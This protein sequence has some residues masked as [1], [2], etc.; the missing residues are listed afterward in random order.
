MPIRINEIIC[1]TEDEKK[2]LLANILG[3]M[4]KREL[5]AGAYSDDTNKLFHIA[6]SI[7]DNRNNNVIMRCIFTLHEREDANEILDIDFVLPNENLTKIKFIEKY[8][9]SSLANERWQ[10]E[11]NDHHTNI[12]T[13]NRHCYFENLQNKEV[14]VSLSLFPY[15]GIVFADSL[16]DINKEF[17]FKPT[18][19][20]WQEALNMGD[21][22]I[23]LGFG[24]D[25]V[26]MNMYVG[27]VADVKEY[28]FNICN[29][30]YKCI[31]AD[32]VTGLGKLPVIFSIDY[33]EQISKGKY[34]KFM[35]ETKADF[36]SNNRKFYL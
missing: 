21:E 6:F 32:I 7:K 1:K 34:V 26:G 22:P 10:I 33:K 14:E 35:A 23:T 3:L 28:E 29:G 36:S 2:D 17:G 15:E 8:D 16:D 30:A 11:Y 31:I 5:F 25:F 13:V 4:D 27:K 19:Y 12:E 9:E 18:K 24:E 20:K